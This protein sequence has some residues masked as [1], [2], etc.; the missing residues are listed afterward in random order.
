MPPDQTGRLRAACAIGLSPGLLE[1]FELSFESG[2][3]GQVTRLG[4]IL[5]RN[6]DEARRNAET[7]KEFDLLGTQV[8]VPI[9][10]RETVVGVAIFDGH[11]TGE[12]LSNP[13]LELIFHL[14][15]QVGL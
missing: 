14:L 12:A 10:D 3:G 11:I 7:Q 8:A 9:L 15:E 13:E 6:S 1:H 4:R 5:R 2:I